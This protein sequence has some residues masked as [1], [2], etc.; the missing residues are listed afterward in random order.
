MIADTLPC[1]LSVTR[2]AAALNAVC[3]D[4]RILPLVAPAGGPVDVTPLLA[5]PRNVFMLGEHGGLC[6]R[7]CA[8]RVYDLH[9]FILPSASARWAQKAISQFISHM[10]F[11]VG[12]RMLW[13][14]IPLSNRAARLSAR[15]HGF[16]AHHKVTLAGVEHEVLELCL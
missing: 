7:W 14:Q 3:N 16:T 10:R 13:A 4:P 12:A 5:D 1:L 6:S 2:D 11:P 8:P 15:R 9:S